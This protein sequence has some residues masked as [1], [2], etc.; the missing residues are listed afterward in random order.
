MN[1]KPLELEETLSLNSSYCLWEVA[2]LA[3]LTVVAIFPHELACIL[4]HWYGRCSSSQ[5]LR[6]IPTKDSLDNGKK[7]TV[8]SVEESKTELTVHDD[9]EHSI[10]DSLLHDSVRRRRDSQDKP[11]LI[12]ASIPDLNASS[13]TLSTA[14]TTEGPRSSPQKVS[15]KPKIGTVS[16]RLKEQ[17][18]RRRQISAGNKS[19]SS[20]LDKAWKPTAKLPMGQGLKRRVVSAD[21][22]VLTGDHS[23]SSSRSRSGS[24]LRISPA[25]STPARV[26]PSMSMSDR[27][28][29]NQIRLQG[30]S[31]NNGDF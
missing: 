1:T 24:S 30:E 3:I 16:Q 13:T 25:Q 29:W 5:A 21:N 9:E 10:S 23:G 22:S 6:K 26:V 19:C 12:F 8:V 20:S 2:I 18:K 17:L 11:D 31:F 7:L 14:T 28:I 27:R 15:P 4:Q